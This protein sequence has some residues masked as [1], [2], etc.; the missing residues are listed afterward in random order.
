MREYWRRI[1]N[2]TAHEL[3]G[4]KTEQLFQVI[5][6]A[7]E[8]N[9][10]E[11]ALILIYSGIDAM[12]WLDSPAGQEDVTKTDFLNWCE[13]YLLHPQADSN[14]TPLDLYAAR[15]GLLHLHTADSRLYRQ[16][17]VT[18]LFYSRKV[19]T[20][21]IGFDQMK[22]D[23]EWPMWAD[24]DILLQRFRSGVNTFRTDV[25]S[26]AEGDPYQAAVVYDRV[27]TTYFVEVDVPDRDPD[28]N[29]TFDD[30]SRYEGRNRRYRAA[31]DD[32]D[33]NDH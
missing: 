9:C 5:S 8:G 25:A 12:S 4:K 28:T 20:G 7:L 21:E 3:W 6:V 13:K 17:K 26:R 31:V 29:L 1:N 18:K 10:I 24:V 32:E 15:C 22:V 33:T 23:K 16:G 30:E 11:P 27:R 14:L 2:A 19:Q